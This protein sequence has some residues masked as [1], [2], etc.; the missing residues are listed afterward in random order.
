MTA[1]LEETPEAVFHEV[2]QALH[3]NIG[4]KRLLVGAR[5]AGVHTILISGGF[6]QVAD[7]VA[8]Q[9]GFD[10]VVCNRLE[11]EGGLLTG[12]VIEPEDIAVTRG[13]R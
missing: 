2:G 4:A 3:L 7:P 13:V 10:E 6:A 5:A 11:I 1:R 12:K 9:L 8:A